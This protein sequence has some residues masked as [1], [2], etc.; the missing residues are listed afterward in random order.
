MA[1]DNRNYLHRLIYIYSLLLAAVALPLSEFLLSLSQ[2]FLVGNWLLE[3]EFKRK[4]EILRKNKALLIFLLLYAV[5]IIWLF[6]TTDFSYALKDLRIK[7]PLLVFPLIIATTRPLTYE[8]LKKILRYF[9]NSVLVATFIMFVLFLH[10][11]DFQYDNVKHISVF[12]SHIRFSLMLV[13][14]IFTQLYFLTKELNNSKKFH[15]ILTVIWEIIFL[16]ILQA[17]TGIIIFS[18]LLPVFLLWLIRQVKNYRTVKT[19]LSISIILVII[20]PIAFIIYS[21]NRFYKTDNVDFKKLPSYTALHNPYYHDTTRKIIEN[22]HY[23]W[24]NVSF[25]ELKAGWN[26]ISKIP[27]DSLDK[28]GQ[29]IRYTLIR[30]LTSKGLT[31]DAQGL[32]QLSNEDI[33]LIEN[34]ETNYLAKNEFSPYYIIYK[35]L[36]EIDVYKKTGNANNHSVTQRFEFLKAAMHIIKNNFWFG[37]GTGDVKQEYFNYYS[38]SHTKLKPKFWLRAHNQFVTFLLTF[39]IFGFIIVLIAIFVPPV[40]TKA[41]KLFLFNLFF[42]I[43]LFSFLNED[44]LETQM[45]VTFF[46]F[47]Y[48]IFVFGY[49]KEEIER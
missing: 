26:K 28:K 39:G 6:N 1:R 14:S 3:G 10:C 40:L 9:N 5:H 33:K 21:I 22:G 2:F 41:H 15:L 12:I 43:V 45:G 47:F 42:A 36:W 38:N 31:K 18:V 49:D 48:S 20:S 32:K 17:R 24:I 30:Y 19:F 46:S 29:K 27:F 37:T 8:E 34:G 23:V 11:C 35:I 4:K 13:L 16:F 25:K 44:T 7:L